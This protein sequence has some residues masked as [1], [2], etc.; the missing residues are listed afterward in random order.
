MT[1][2]C[3]EKTLLAVLMFY[4]LNMELDLQG[5]FGLLCRAVLIG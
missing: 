4:R 3:F 2:N 5:L 1:D